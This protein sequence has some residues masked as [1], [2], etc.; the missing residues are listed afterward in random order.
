SVGKL[1]AIGDW[2]I[3]PLEGEMPGRA[4]G[5]ASRQPLSPPSVAF[6]DISPSRGEINPVA[7]AILAETPADIAA[8]EA[9]LDRAMGPG[10]KRK[11]SEQLRRGRRPSAGLAFAAKDTAGR[12]VGTVRL[13]DVAFGASCDQP[14]G[15]LLLGP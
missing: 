6:G 15:F 13:W 10:R 8:R 14:Q 7:P 1:D 9:L 2:P 11:S 3:S 5:G 4:E 12:L